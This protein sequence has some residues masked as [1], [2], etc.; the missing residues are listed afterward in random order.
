MT[1]SCDY[2]FQFGLTDLLLFF[3]VE[4]TGNAGTACHPSTNVKAI[5]GRRDIL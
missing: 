1:K 3:G 4:A 5:I 2:Y